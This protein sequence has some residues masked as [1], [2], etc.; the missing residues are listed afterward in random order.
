MSSTVILKAAGLNTSPNELSVPEGSLSDASNVLIRRDG[1]VEQRRGFKLYGTPGATSNDRVKQ[2]TT[3]RN[4]II[5]HITDKLQFDSDG[6]GTFLS[7][8]GSFLEADPSLRMKFIESNGNLYFTSS[9]GIQKVSAKTAD[10]LVTSTIVTAGAAKAIDITG[11]II[12]TPNSQT[13]FLPQDSVVAY[14]V[15]WGYKDANNNLIL[16]EPSQRE[17]VYNHQITLMLLDYM[18]FLGALDSFSNTPLSTARINDKNYVSTLGLT[19]SASTSD[20][21]TNLISLASKLDNDIL[22]ANEA[23][24]APMTIVSAVIVSGICTITV[25]GANASDY[26]DPGSKIFL[27]GFTGGT[28]G[29]INGSQV[30]VSATTTTITFNVPTTGTNPVPPTGSFTVTGSTINS[31]EFRSIVQPPETQIP[32]IHIDNLDVQAY[33]SSILN[34]LRTLPDLVISA[35]D[36]LILD[37]VDITT[38]ATVKLVISIP[39][40]IDSR[41]FYQVYRSAIFSASNELSIDDVVPNDE[42]QLVYEAFPTPAQ[43]TAREITLIDITPD[44]FRGAN[45]YTNNS[46]GEGILQANGIPPYAL[47]INR[48]RNV[49]FYANTRT[50]HQTLLNLLGVQNMITDFNNGIIPSITIATAFGAN[51]YKFV[52]GLQEITTITTV[53]D[54]AN[55]LNSTYFLI[56][57]TTGA[58]YYFYFETSTA[59]DPMITGRTGVKV[60]IPTNATANQVASALRDK[61]S[62]LLSDYEVSVSTNIVTVTDVISGSVPDAIDFDTGFTFLVTQQGRGEDIINKT[63]LLS[64]NV[65]PAVAVD[66]TARSLIRVINSNANESIYGFYLSG[67][68]DVP[69]KMVFQARNLSADSQFFILA[70]N[71]ATGNSFNPAIVPDAQ[72]TSITLGLN[73]VITTSIPHGMQNLDFVVLGNTNS[74]PTIDGVYAITYIS[75]TS[76]SISVSPAVTIAGTLGAMSRAVDVLTSENETKPNRVYY[77]KINQPEAVPISNFFDVGAQDKAILRI[78]PLRDSLFVFKEDGLYRISGDSAPFQ[79]N[80]FDSSFIV[81]ASDSV[82]VS[83]NVIFAWTKQGIQSLTEGGAGVVSRPIDNQVLKLGSNNYLHFKTATWGVGY[84]SDNSYIVWTVSDFDDIYAMKGFRYST[85]TRSWTTYDKTNTCGIVSTADDKL[86]LGAGDT[87]YTEQERKLFDRTDFADRE[88]QFSLANNFLVKP[89]EI[90]LTS[91]T[92]ISIGDVIVQDQSLTTFEFNTFLQKLDSDPSINEHNFLSTLE[93][94]A[95]DNPRLRLLSLAATLDANPNIVASNFV[96]QVDDYNGTITSISAGF[97]AIITSVGHNLITGRVVLLTGSDST[98]SINGTFPV[99]V[100]DADHFSIPFAVKIPGTTGNFQTLGL[101]TGDLMLCY[102]RIC[103]ILNADVGVS[104]NNYRHID[105]DTIQESIILDI[106]K[107]SKHLILN[108]GLQY[109]VGDITV[110]KAIT[111][112]LTYSPISMGDPLNLKHLREATVMFQTRNITAATLSF[113][114]DLLPE[115]IPIPFTLDGNGIFGHN[116]FGTGFFGGSS[117]SAP[118]RTFIPRQCQRCRFIVA[119]FTHSVAREDYRLLGMTI[120]GE[121]GQSTRAYR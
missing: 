18:R 83:N 40:D 29:T 63:V 117:N 67:A 10:N 99:I 26:L 39:Q 72:I 27:A 16:G 3:Y 112:T 114:T 85:L 105:N 74:T 35:A 58:K 4:R 25:S 119:Q 115:L 5:R 44:D 97:P 79:L 62:I 104:F 41:Y 121:V 14:R 64:T 9:N 89:T 65:S 95:G 76:F 69:G 23:A 92:G 111:S 34:A 22:Y 21:R 118:F 24:T 116:N 7:F 19:A 8:A 90:K 2:L 113:A 55:S 53:A 107:V 103:D 42:L 56:D 70:N 33:M 15:V 61:I 36:Q 77:S 88:L 13:G 47:D 87:N 60:S 31:N 82:N 110:Y 59:V 50:K 28:T 109:L 17:I 86:Y 73:P 71:A 84:E 68:F 101:N 75:S 66:E 43:L 81:T 52:T 20:L 96:S 102:N 106:N 11:S 32:P 12:Y 120:T 54:I 45:L 46:T 30:V 78:F 98:P 6:T 38:T 100:I 37:T 1:I 91:I 94:K 108:I 51:T 49:V 48:Y 80:L 93:L 57:S